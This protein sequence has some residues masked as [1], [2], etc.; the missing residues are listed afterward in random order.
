[1]SPFA[2]LDLFHY[3]CRDLLVSFAVSNV[4]GLS[5]FSSSAHVQVHGGKQG[6]N[7]IGR[8]WIKLLSSNSVDLNCYSLYVD[9]LDSQ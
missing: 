8:V 6:E 4:A 7:L 5:N 3:A 1:M 9:S 2:Q